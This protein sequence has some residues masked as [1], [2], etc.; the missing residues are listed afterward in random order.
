MGVGVVFVDQVVGG[1]LYTGSHDCTMRVWDV[2]NIKGDTQFGLDDT[3]NTSSPAAAAAAASRPRPPSKKNR[4][5]A[6]GPVKRAEKPRIMIGD[7][8][9]TNNTKQG[10]LI[11]IGK[12]TSH[13]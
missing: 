12:S 3:D 9:C 2:S 13:F 7:D 4:Q 11:S 8:D 1:K 6:S 10:H 5:A